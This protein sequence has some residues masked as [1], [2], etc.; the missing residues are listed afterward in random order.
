M[1]ERNGAEH[2]ETQHQPNLKL[3]FVKAKIPSKI[4]Q[5][6]RTYLENQTDDYTKIFQKEYYDLETF[7]KAILKH[8][9]FNDFQTVH[10]Y[11]H[12][13]GDKNA[14][15]LEVEKRIHKSEELPVA[16]FNSLF[17]SI[18]KSRNRS[19]GQSKIKGSNFN[20]I[21][22]FLGHE[23]QLTNYNLIFIISRGDFLPQNEKEINSFKTLCEIMPFTLNFLLRSKKVYND[24][25]LVEQL[26]THFPVPI[27]LKKEDHL[28]AATNQL[29]QNN[30]VHF[31]KD[32]L[33]VKI[34]TEDDLDFI[35]KEKI[36]LLGDLLNTLRHELANPIFGLSLTSNLL[37]STLLDEENKELMSEISSSLSRSQKILDNFTNLFNATEWKQAS[38]KEIINEAFTLSKSESRSV[39]RNINFNGLDD[40]EIK[41][42]QTWFF[43]ILFNL[44]INASQAL[45]K[46]SHKNPEINIECVQMSNKLQI[47]FYDNGPGIPS[48][49]KDNIFLP[50]FTTKEKGTGLGL[51]ISYN[52]ALKLG[53]R[54]ELIKTGNEGTHFRLSLNTHEHTHN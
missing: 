21:G 25:S 54:L 1:E 4:N 14:T 42:N 9:N 27:T 40:I 48:E 5:Y 16:D 35:H 38:V 44:I 53:G 43:Q 41:T 50:F 6:Y 20:I 10:L 45:K 30:P 34:E 13:K 32:N 52:L 29:P 39:K 47:D 22:T 28:L 26:F 23:F 8:K 2:Q 37:S 46:A 12:H 36:M 49:I 18:K 7:C 15:H 51:S 3:D 17:Q 24:L 31:S 33:E 11:L 19:F